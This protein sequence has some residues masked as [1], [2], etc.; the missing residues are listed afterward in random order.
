MPSTSVEGHKGKLILGTVSG[1]RI[2]CLAGRIHPYEGYHMYQLTFMIRILKR[3]GVELFISTNSSG[4]CQ[5]GMK[6]SPFF[7]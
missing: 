4:G 7:D 6:V 5:P 3:V 2:M 1:K